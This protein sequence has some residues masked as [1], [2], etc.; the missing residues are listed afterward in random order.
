MIGWSDVFGLWFDIAFKEIGDAIDACPAQLWEA[1]LWDVTKDPARPPLP[2]GPD[3]GAHPL[4]VP[5]LS[6][7][8]KVAFHALAATEW[9]F[10][11]RPPDFQL[12]APFS[13]VRR[14]FSE[15]GLNGMAISREM[16]PLRPPSK[17]DLTAYLEHN[18]GLAHARMSAAHDH[19][20]G[21]STLGPW[22]GPTDQLLQLFHGSASHL[23]A[24][25]VELQMFLNQHRA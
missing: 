4:G 14:P 21:Q 5:V 17:E 20:D 8:W 2:V 22:S 18:K 1:G 6:A 3:G 23:M 19:E 24:H 12:G 11:G 13:D 25:N 16:L 7:F 15:V 9:N 10:G